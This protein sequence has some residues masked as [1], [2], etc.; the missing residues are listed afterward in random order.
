VR[1]SV[2][3]ACCAVTVPYVTHMY[4]F[5]WHSPL[6]LYRETDAVVKQLLNLEREVCR[7]KC[8]IVVKITD[9]VCGPITLYKRTFSN[10]IMTQQLSVASESFKL[11]ASIFNVSVKPY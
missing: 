6:R 8:T 3:V 9:L 10:V 1:S 2:P 5:Y 7:Y 11:L 4:C